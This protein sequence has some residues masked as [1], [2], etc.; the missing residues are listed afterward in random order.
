[1]WDISFYILLLTYLSTQSCLPIIDT[2]VLSEGQD[3]IESVSKLDK[4][5]Y[6]PVPEF[7]PV[8]FGEA[9]ST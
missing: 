9:T 5:C 4:N 1:M 3:P 6:Q 2:I 7:I 8:D